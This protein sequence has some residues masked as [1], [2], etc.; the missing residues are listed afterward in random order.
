M[1]LK[2]NKDRGVVLK[3]KGKF[4]NLLHTDSF[5]QLHH[6]PAKTI[7]GNFE[8]SYKNIGGFTKQGHLLEQFT[9]Q[10]NGTN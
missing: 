3:Y 7:E 10:P 9:A 4:L 6:D 5:F 1:V 2:Q 8:G